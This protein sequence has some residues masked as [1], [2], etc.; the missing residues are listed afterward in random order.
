[1][2]GMIIII[3]IIYF[4]LDVVI[5]YSGKLSRGGKTFANFVDLEPFVKVFSANFEGR[6]SQDHVYIR[7][8]T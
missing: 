2:F 3:T 6:V 1:M 8:Y 5:P 7:I 4:F